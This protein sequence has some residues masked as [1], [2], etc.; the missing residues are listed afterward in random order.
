MSFLFFL[1]CLDPRVCNIGSKASLYHNRHGLMGRRYYFIDTEC[2]Q[3][4]D[5]TRGRGRKREIHGSSFHYHF[6]Q[7]QGNV[8][9][10]SQKAASMLYHWR[11]KF[12]N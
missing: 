8:C 1:S 2:Y 3:S 7:A 5:C 10:R 11:Y 4:D 6:T 12:P 9:H